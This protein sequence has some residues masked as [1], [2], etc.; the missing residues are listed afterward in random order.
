MVDDFAC[1]LLM[2]AG[3]NAHALHLNIVL[4]V[5]ISFYTFHMISY[6]VDVYHRKL[7][8][9]RSYVDYALFVTCFPQRPVLD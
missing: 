9:C 3:L 6:V 1:Y 2:R 5:G 7:H 8:A 4:P